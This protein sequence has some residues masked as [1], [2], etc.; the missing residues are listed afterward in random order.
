MGESSQREGN[1]PPRRSRM[2]DEVLEILYR[3]DQP[4]SFA[5]HV[6]RK[7]TRQRRSRLSTI[8]RSFR[9]TQQLGPG[10]M[11][12]ASI[13]AALLAVLVKDAS[14]ILAT[15]LA[16]ASV[17]LLLAPIV[18]RYRRPGRSDVKRW[19]GRDIDLNPPPPAW[20]GSLRDRFRKPPRF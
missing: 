3:T 11:L 5:D 2:E 18:G 1:E 7:T 4:T 13:G 12:L 14:A 8:S 6:R 17:S 19:R 16:L 15:L 10:T 20:V 9:T